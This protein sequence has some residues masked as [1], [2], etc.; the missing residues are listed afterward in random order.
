M[1]GLCSKEVDA[2]PPNRPVRT[3]DSTAQ[4]AAAPRTKPQKVG[5][6]ARTLGGGAVG[7]YAGSAAQN[8][9]LAAEVCYIDL[10]NSLLRPQHIPVMLFF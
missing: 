1:G 9:A 6:P 5:G 3:L 8:A 2:V 7:T 10:F 4:T